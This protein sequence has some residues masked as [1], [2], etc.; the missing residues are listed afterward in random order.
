MSSGSPTAPTQNNT[1]G[2]PGE[3]SDHIHG[4]A[5]TNENANT[6]AYTLNGDTSSLAASTY[7]QNYQCQNPQSHYTNCNFYAGDH[8][9]AAQNARASDRVSSNIA[10]GTGRAHPAQDIE[11]NSLFI[12][13]YWP[14]NLFNSF[15][16]VVLRAAAMHV[17]DRAPHGT[18]PRHTQD[19]EEPDRP[20]RNDR[21]PSPIPSLTPAIGIQ[22]D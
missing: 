8:S 22:E 6:L 13:F 5:Y 10:M 12:P 7:I 1:H 11:Q 3:S 4:S 18:L 19:L 2:I 20:I 15:I 16:R 17:G 21:S 9:L 14:W